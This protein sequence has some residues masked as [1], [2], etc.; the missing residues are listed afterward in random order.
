MFAV[1]VTFT[2]K[3]GTAQEFMPLMYENAATSLRDEP[4]CHQFDVATNPEQPNEVFLYELY[5]DASAFESHKATPHFLG[6]DAATA[7]MIV[8]KNVS[9]YAKVVQ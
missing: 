7:D 6:F 4:G 8:A 9:T 3:S 2:L 5:T 1:V